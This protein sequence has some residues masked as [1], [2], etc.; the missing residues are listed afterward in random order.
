MYVRRRFKGFVC[1]YNQNSINENYTNE[2]NYA[3]ESGKE[4]NR[5][6]QPEATKFST[7]YFF[8]VE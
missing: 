6:P 7:H 1:A 3:F 5:T 2:I 4:R 8:L